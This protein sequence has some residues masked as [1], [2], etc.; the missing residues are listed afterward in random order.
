MILKKRD[1]RD[2][3]L[4]ELQALLTYELSEKQRFLIEREIN[5]IKIGKFGEDDSAYY[6]DFYYGNSKRWIVIHDLRI[7]LEGRVAQ[8][9]HI[10][11]NRLF[12]VYILETKNYKYGIRVSENEE[13]EVYYK[14]RYFGIPSPTEQ[15][16]RH[17][18][19]L[20]SLIKKYELTPSRLSMQIIPTFHNF[21]LLSPSSIIK[22]PKS[23]KTVF[24]DI[25]KA[26]NLT[27]VI[28]KSADN[29]NALE[30]FASISK[31]SSFESIK[32]F[33]KRLVRFHKQPHIDW[34][35][36]FGITESQIA[37]KKTK[38]YFCAK[39]KANISFKEAKFC[40]NNKERFK[41]RA[42]CYN[43]QKGFK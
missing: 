25:I 30:A 7:E 24:S 35:K 1:S 4:K 15:N 31:V 16:K 10:L 3:D 39:C 27:T 33:G 42:F 21:I 20:K 22:R 41:G 37:D 43:C 13:F 32:E 29:I 34:K 23:K 14:N 12:D 2:K 38:R 36:K 18:E 11:I 19:V 5:A 40:W 8:I 26:D 17:I 28:E 6:I 9:D